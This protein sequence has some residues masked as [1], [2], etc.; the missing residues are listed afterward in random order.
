MM[1]N[2]TDSP[3][4]DTSQPSIDSTTMAPLCAPS[5]VATSR[6]R[7]SNTPLNAPDILNAIIERDEIFEAETLMH[8]MR[9]QG[10]RVS[11]ATVYRTLKLL[12]EAGIINQTL[13]D[14]N[15]P[16]TS[17]STDAQTLIP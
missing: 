10:D 8:E 17:W 7:I 9:S 14:G 3:S 15:R 13:F 2:R 1:T 16:T 4:G 6:N 5:F 12:Q 11:K